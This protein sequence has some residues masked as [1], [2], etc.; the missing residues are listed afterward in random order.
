VARVSDLSGEVIERGAGA[1]L[2]LRFEGARRELTLD[3]TEEEAESLV[4][5]LQPLGDA[6]AARSYSVDDIRSQHPRAYVPW[7]EGEEEEL[8]A[9]FLA[10]T[11]KNE[12]ALRLGRQ[13]SAITSRLRRLDLQ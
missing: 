9:L 3:L 11:N 1:T 2:I 4:A 12:I 6:N 5:T 10:G 13:P 8:R 7:S